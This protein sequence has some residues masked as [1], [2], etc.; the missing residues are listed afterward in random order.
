MR[1][2]VLSTASMRKRGAVDVISRR[3][4]DLAAAAEQGDPF[5]TGQTRQH[6]GL[7]GATRRAPATVEALLTSPTATT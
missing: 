5:G 4:R 2:T 6:G 3:P 7:R 1:W